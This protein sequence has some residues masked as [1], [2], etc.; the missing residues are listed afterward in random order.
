MEASGWIRMVVENQVY[1]FP[2]L[3]FSECPNSCPKIR[4]F[5][6]GVAKIMGQGNP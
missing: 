6:E 2:R 5:L 3:L 4:E 1:P